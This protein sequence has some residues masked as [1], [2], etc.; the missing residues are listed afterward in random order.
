[1]KKLK[2]KQPKRRQR[3][4]QKKKGERRQEPGKVHRKNI[5]I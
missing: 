3:K 2:L 5:K 4:K 1:M